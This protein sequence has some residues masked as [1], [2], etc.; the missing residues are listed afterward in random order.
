MRYNTYNFWRVLSKGEP[1]NE[2]EA[3]W[4][5]QALKGDREA[6]AKLVELYQRPVYNLAYRL[7]GDPYEAEDAA[8]EAFLR[9]FTHLSY[10]D[11]NRKFSSWLLSITSHYCI[12]L[13]RRRRVRLRALREMA[14]QASTNS[15]NSP[16]EPDERQEVQELLGILQP[17]DKAVVVLRYWYEFSCREIGQILGLT[18]SAVKSKLYRARKALA[19]EWMNRHP[20]QEGAR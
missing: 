2:A 1:M 12:D 15:H 14:R 8:Q 5:E 4:V 18:E 3:L 6:F 10:Y 13:L 19:E 9:A 16:I 11:R 7:L 20:Y 17:L